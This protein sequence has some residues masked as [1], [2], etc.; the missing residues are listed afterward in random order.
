MRKL[1]FAAIFIYGCTL[2]SC[3]KNLINQNPTPP[4]VVSEANLNGWV[5]RVRAEDAGLVPGFTITPTNEID[6]FRLRAR[7]KPQ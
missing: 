6:A 3:K 5:M 4:V 2:T 1:I 7:R